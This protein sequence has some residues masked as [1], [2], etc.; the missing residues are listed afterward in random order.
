ML[1][2]L[3]LL[4]GRYGVR[5]PQAS[6]TSSRRSKYLCVIWNNRKIQLQDI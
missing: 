4:A 3:F 1:F 5:A 6:A 2:C